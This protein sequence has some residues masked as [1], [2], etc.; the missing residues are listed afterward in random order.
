[1][2]RVDF[3]RDEVTAETLVQ[4]VFAYLSCCFE[5]LEYASYHRSFPSLSAAL[6]APAS[7]EASRAQILQQ[8]KAEW[9]TILE[10]EKT[11]AGQLLLKRHCL[12]TTFQSFRELHSVCERHGYKFGEPI[13]EVVKAWFPPFGQSSNLENVFRELE[14]AVRKSGPPQDSLTNLACVA[15]RSLERRIC[16]EK[17]VTPATPEL[18]ERDWEGK[19][20]RALKNRIWHPNSAMP[21]KHIRLED[22]LKPFPTTSA[23]H[24][25]HHGLNCLLGWKSA[26][27]KG[28]SPV[29]ASQH[30]WV[31]SCFQRGVVFRHNGKFFMCMGNTYAVIHAVVLHETPW[32]F[33]GQLPPASKENRC[34]TQ[35]KAKRTIEDCFRKPEDSTKALCFRR[36]QSNYTSVFIR[37]YG[38][39]NSKEPVE[40]FQCTFH[41]ADAA[42]AAKTGSILIRR[43]PDGWSLLVFLFRTER[44]LTITSAALSELLNLEGLRLPKNAAK[45]AKIR[46]LMESAAVVANTD[47]IF[48]DRI[49]AQLVHQEQK[50]SKRKAETADEQDDEGDA[51]QAEQDID[52]ACAACEQLLVEMEKEDAA[53]LQVE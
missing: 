36:G 5:L 31:A 39:S 12:F 13:R 28:E 1:V 52:P 44:I 18:T 3:S 17:N 26:I 22:I 20:I 14:S 33:T 7:T 47:Q 2:L 46:K 24:W 16:N 48:R 49:E 19:E 34:A 37:G 32:T 50:K 9:N 10:M 29:D 11:T 27:E 6:L 15:V 40:I 23:H 42:R 21:C 4:Q 25:T 45:A 38:K 43:A 35:G 41:V 30:F 51:E 8:A 53:D